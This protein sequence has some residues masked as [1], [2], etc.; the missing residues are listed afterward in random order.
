MI[1]VDANILL[2][3]YDSTSAMH[4]KARSW[5]EQ[6]FAGNELAA[7]PWQTISAFVRIVTNPRL[8]GERFTAGEA[9]QVVE[10]WLAQPNVRAIG[11]GERHWSS[12]RQM[13]IG[14]QASGPLTTDAAL[15]A[16]TIEH[17]GVLYTTD[18][19]FARFPGLRWMNPLA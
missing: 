7:L 9:V 13:L 3:A 11:P 2:Y 10:D 18:R 4:G 16:L 15:A 5:V 14:G 8:A 17:G 6:I 1:V 19:D 12:F